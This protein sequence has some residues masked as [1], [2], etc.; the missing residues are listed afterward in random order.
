[1]DYL[2]MGKLD[3]IQ[4]ATIVR[5]VAAA[6]Q[7]I[8]CTL[9]GGETAEMPDVYLPTAFDLAGTIVGIVEQDALVDN[10]TISAGDVLLGLPSSGLHTNG[11]SLARRVF[12]PYPLDTVFPELGEPLVDA[13][14]RP[15][16]SYLRELLL[17]R[18][19]PDISI[20]GLAHI[21]GGGFEGNLAR[22]LPPGRQA[23]IQTNTWIVSP[24]FQLI[25]RL[26]HVTHEEMYRTFNMGMGF[27]AIVPDRQADDALRILNKHFHARVVGRMAVGSGVWIPSLD[28]RF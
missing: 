10:N 26:G 1:M 23:V 28:L 17:L 13:L 12:A 22:I 14:L 5:S 11:Y 4:A 3:P 9:L 25:A 15:H 21:T 7:E 20:K 24:L 2:A 6:C 18:E 27:A 16:R 19:H 8:G